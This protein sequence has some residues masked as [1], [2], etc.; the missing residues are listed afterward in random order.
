MPPGDLERYKGGI[1]TIVT[2]V[3]YLQDSMGIN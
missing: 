3:T 1:D 2:A